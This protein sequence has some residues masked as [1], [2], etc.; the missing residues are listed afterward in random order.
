MGALVGIKNPQVEQNLKS[1]LENFIFKKTQIPSQIGSLNIHI[2][3]PGLQ[4]ED[5]TFYR[6]SEEQ[7]WVKIKRIKLAV[8]LWP[9][10]QGDWVLNR[11]IVDGLNANLILPANTQN[12]AEV[13]SSSFDTTKKLPFDIQHLAFWNTNLLI[14]RGDSLLDIRKADFEIRPLEQDKRSI[15][16]AVASGHLTHAEHDIAFE[17]ILKAYLRGSLAQPKAASIEHAYVDLKRITLEAAGNMEFDDS[18]AHFDVGFNGKLNFDQIRRII[19]DI[20]NID[21]ELQFHTQILGT[22]ANPSIHV[23]IETDELYYD[24]IDYGQIKLAT[25]YKNSRLRA[26]SIHYKHKSIGKLTGSGELDLGG[27]QN[28]TI[29]SR[30]HNFKLEELLE[31]VDIPHAWV[32]LDLSGDAEITGKLAGKGL[33]LKLDTLVNNFESLDRTYRSSQAEKL[34]HLKKLRLKGNTFLTTQYIDLNNIDVGLSK[35]HYQ[36]NGTLRFEKMNG[37]NIRVKSSHANL[38]DFGHIAGL[39]FLGHGEI[40]AALEGP[41]AGPTISGTLNLNEASIAGY[42]IGDLRTTIIYN[43]NKLKLERM[44]GQ[45]DGGRFTGAVNLNF[46]L[47]PTL[48]SGALNLYDVPSAPLLRD[49]GINIRSAEQIRGKLQGMVSVNGALTQPNGFFEATTKQLSLAQISLDENHIRGGFFDKDH[50]LWVEIKKEKR[51][52]PFDFNLY[53]KY[54]DT[55]KFSAKWLNLKS[56]RFQKLVPEQKLQGTLSGDLELAGPFSNIEG[57]FSAQAKDLSV[58][59]VQFKNLNVDV[60][61][62]GTSIDLAANLFDSKPNLRLHIETTKHNPFV[63]ELQLNGL[64]SKDIIDG[65]PNY[66]FLTSGKIALNGFIEKPKQT[67]GAI[68]LKRLELGWLENKLVSKKGLDVLIQKQKVILQ[69]TQFNAPG[70]S[71]ATKGFYHFNNSLSFDLESK[72]DLSV[73]SAI[74]DSIEFARGPFS[75]KIHAEGPLEEL[76][77]NGTGNISNA[78]LLLSSLG[79]PLNEI[80]M[81]FNIKDRNFNITSASASTGQGMMKLRGSAHFPINESAKLEFEVS[82]DRAHLRPLPEIL[83]TTTGQLRYIGNGSK[84][85]ISGNLDLDTLEYTENLELEHLI[86]RRQAISFRQGAGEAEP[87]TL[88]IKLNAPNNLNISNSLI[89]AELQADLLLTGTIENMGLIGTISPLWAKVKYRENTFELSRGSLNFTEEYRIFS[90]F[91]FRATTS[92]CGMDILVDI[93]GNSDSYHIIPSGKDTQGSVNPQDALACLQFG[94]RLEDFRGANAAGL[95]DTL[96]GSLDALWTV[97]GLDEKVRKLLPAPVIDQFR[98][99]SGWSSK[100]QKTTARLLIG[101]GIGKNMELTYSRSIEAITDQEFSLRYKLSPIATVQGTWASDNEVPVGDLGLD[102]KLR[103]EF[104]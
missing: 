83:I 71:L 16:L 96:P 32:R 72:G 55:I 19:T 2:W 42:R 26:N 62:K 74:D 28:F 78:A 48:I 4:L 25:V 59:D 49:L 91:D 90:E 15:Q 86:P 65:L 69:P 24:E 14:Q 6:P 31:R 35:N 76:S 5:L 84:Q 44:H 77:Y 45:R 47:N 102:L 53:W 99:T 43:Q 50:V 20:P 79:E 61:K 54:D 52:E 36:I 89:E 80:E 51:N 93:E 85:T 12:N 104:R 81:L 82:L 88:A 27:D 94:L 13:K 18:G 92:A 66:S 56:N 75:T 21:G 8:Q 97:S 29:N 95:S 87:T 73:L 63:L 37:F 70:L 17:T 101:K 57:F 9:N 100:S 46:A 38:Q 40:A 103:W 34:L 30:L 23:S 11:L 67:R 60:K 41:Y 10:Q 64:D 98:L 39:E 7:P 22:P 68:T 58:G 33:K 3:P 1:H